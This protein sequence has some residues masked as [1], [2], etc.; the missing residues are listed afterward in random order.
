MALLMKRCVLAAKLEAVVGT[1]E[2]LAATDAQFVARDVEITPEAPYN[3][4]EAPGTMSNLPGV[5]GARMGSATFT[6][7]LPGAGSDANPAWADTFLPA[8][9]FPVPDNVGSPRTFSFMS[10]SPTGAVDNT[11]TLT[12]GKFESG[13][14][15]L[16]RGA[17]GTGRFVFENGQIPLLEV[18]LTGA[19]ESITDAAVVAPTLPDLVP[20]RCSNLTVTLGGN[21]FETN[22][23]ELDFSSSVKLIEDLSTG[24]GESGYKHAVVTDRDPTVTFQRNSQLVATDD[25]YGQ[26]LA[27]TTQALV[28]NVGGAIWN[29]LEFAAPA[30]QYSGIA[31]ADNDGVMADD[32][33]A[34]LVRSAANDDELTLTFA[35]L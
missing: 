3:A 33:T 11:R 14:L 31:P 32:C 17:M 12:V 10:T 24:G 21:T 28:L 18:E 23:I 7:E 25:I 20:P 35:A 27:G 2:T 29:K 34:K 30:A 1:A 4:R 9:G 26:W 6:L 15:K 13:R 22:R 19:Y 5:V 8:L 16:L